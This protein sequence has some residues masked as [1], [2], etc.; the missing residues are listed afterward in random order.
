MCDTPLSEKAFPAGKGAVDKLI[1]DDEIPRPQILA[2]AAHSG[3]R[4]DVGH[5]AALQRIDIGA[6]IDLGGRLHVSTTVAG[7]ED[8][9]LP[10]QASKAELIRG[11]AKRAVDSPPFDI[12]E[13]LD[14]VEPAASDDADDRPS[15]VRLGVSVLCR[16]SRESRNPETA[17]ARRLPRPPAFASLSQG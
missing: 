8:D 15:H 13:P 6:K 16:H 12:G 14:L 5:A 3:Q 1:D 2:Q 9:R 11:P 17:R 4:Y 7:H 10:A